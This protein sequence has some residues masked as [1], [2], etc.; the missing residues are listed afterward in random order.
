MLEDRLDYPAASS[1]RVIASDIFVGRSCQFDG[2]HVLVDGTAGTAGRSKRL[3]PALSRRRDFATPN[4]LVKRPEGA[5]VIIFCPR[6]SSL[7][8][9]G[10][11]C[12]WTLGNE[13]NFGKSAVSTLVRLFPP[14]PLAQG[15]LCSFCSFSFR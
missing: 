10:A 7:V 1:P 5:L 13:K 9:N 6:M 12:H 8:R 2:A 15:G 4:H 11:A 14:P 3:A